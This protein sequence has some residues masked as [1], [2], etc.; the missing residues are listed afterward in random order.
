MFTEAER[1]QLRYYLG[2]SRLWLHIDSRL[3]SQMT[4]VQAIADGG[5]F[6][7]SSTEDFIRARLAD[8]AELETDLKALWT[9][10][11]ALDADGLKIDVARAVRT[12][13]G[14]GRR[15]VGAIADALDI[16]P[17][18]SVFGGRP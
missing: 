3:E 12:L 2:F 15:L 8:L 1:V 16:T 9:Q 6:P 7:D 11:Q 13:Y 10:A 5:S 18:R 17:R 14:E 4:T